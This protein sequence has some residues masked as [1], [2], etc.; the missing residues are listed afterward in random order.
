GRR[1]VSRDDWV[2]AGRI[3]KVSEQTRDGIAQHLRASATTA[4]RERGRLDGER[5][6]AA[7]E[8]EADAAMRRM[9]QWITAR[10]EKHPDG[11]TP[12]ALRKAAAS[13]DRDLIEPALTALTETG[14]AVDDGAIYRIRG[15]HG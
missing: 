2:I 15:R 12:G 13:R 10:L 5:R 6:A 11:M 14:A 9:C 4:S 8:S 7:A 1:A 3:V